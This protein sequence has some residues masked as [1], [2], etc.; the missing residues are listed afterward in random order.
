MSANRG[1]QENFSAH[2]A[3]AMYDRDA[4]ERKAQTM[5][6]VLDD[7][8]RTDLRSLS[9]LDIGA[10]TGIIDSYLADHFKT[11]V[12]VDIDRQAI[13]RAAE[14]RDKPNL[15]FALGDAMN[16]PFAD[17]CFDVLICAQIYE[18]VPDATKL[19]S[20]IHRVLKPRGICYF[21]AGN[22]LSINEPHYRLP[23]LSIL[24]RPLAHVYLRLARRGTFYYEKHLSYWGLKAL[25]RRFE[26]IDYTAR[27]VTHPELFHAQYMIRPGTL[28][29]RLARLLLRLAYWA[30]PGYIWLLRKT[31]D[32][33][34]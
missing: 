17:K 33:I 25:V 23:F 12:G 1:Y 13:M 10:S 24:P 34:G 20:E 9:L 32:R 7:F 30:F 18:H 16:L 8:L 29:A 3:D 26:L 27:I 28:K 2:H 6:A 22:R 11:V 19:L 4:R 31:T 14:M 5:V 15:R 21:A